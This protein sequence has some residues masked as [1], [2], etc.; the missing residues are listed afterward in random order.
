[1]AALKDRLLAHESGTYRRPRLR[2]RA[3]AWALGPEAAVCLWEILRQ[4]WPPRVGPEDWPLLAVAGACGLLLVP[5]IMLSVLEEARWDETG[6]EFKWLLCRPRHYHWDELRSVRLPSRMQRRS[7]IG[8][9]VRTS[10]N[11]IIDIDWRGLNYA[12]FQA[13]LVAHLPVENWPRKRDQ[14]LT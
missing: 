14:R 1:M 10:T 13:A 12:A 9:L 5:L 8:L 3:A 4:P 2:W 7:A 6:V 11:E